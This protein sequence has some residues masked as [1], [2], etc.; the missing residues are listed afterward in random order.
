MACMDTSVLLSMGIGRAPSNAHGRM[1]A[2]GVEG[3]K[4]PGDAH[5]PAVRQRRYA[6]VAN[7]RCPLAGGRWEL[8]P[9]GA[10]CPLTRTPRI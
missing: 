8:W 6:A 7:G 3:M 1:R 10:R 5:A 4:P 9:G 2:M